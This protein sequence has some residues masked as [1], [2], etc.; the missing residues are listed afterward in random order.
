MKKLIVLA[1]MLTI[2]SFASIAQDL[3]KNDPGYNINNY[4]HSNKASYAAKKKTATIEVSE[5]VIV[6]RNYKQMANKS[7]EKAVEIIRTEPREV[8]LIRQ[9][10]KMPFGTFKKEVPIKVDTINIED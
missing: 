7:V 2:A 5:N 6:N 8:Y 9:N 1:S 10:Y 4:K 3:H